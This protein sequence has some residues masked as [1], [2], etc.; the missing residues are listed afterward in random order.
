MSGVI[1]LSHSNVYQLSPL[2]QAELDRKFQGNF[3]AAHCLLIFS[4]HH[5]LISFLKSHAPNPMSV[6]PVVGGSDACRR[7][8]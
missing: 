4:I 2:Y 5:P 1:D 7:S 3:S 6:L 8:R